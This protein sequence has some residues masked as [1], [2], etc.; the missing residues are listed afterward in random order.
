[1]NIKWIIGVLVLFVILTML[2]GIIESSTIGADEISR[3]KTL[4]QPELSWGYVENIY[5]ILTFDYSFFQGEWQI[6]RYALFIPIGIGIMAMLVV[7]IISAGLN[8]LTGR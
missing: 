6:V 3:M 8:F 1:M 2:S 4:L 7:T 5:G